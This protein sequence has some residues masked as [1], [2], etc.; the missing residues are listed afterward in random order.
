MNYP[1]KIKKAYKLKY[2]FFLDNSL[3]FINSFF[4]SRKKLISQINKLLIKKNIINVKL[5]DDFTFLSLHI[6]YKKILKKKKEYKNKI[7]FIKK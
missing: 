5:E 7:I 6:I 1:I 2:S 3:A 4:K